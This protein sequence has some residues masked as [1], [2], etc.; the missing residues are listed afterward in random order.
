MMIYRLT[1][2]W[3]YARLILKIAGARGRPFQGAVRKEESV[4]R[5]SNWRAVVCR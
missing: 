2:G 1:A 3:V 5:S 4:T